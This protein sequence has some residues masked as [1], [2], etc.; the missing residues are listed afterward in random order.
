[1][2][3]RVR[4]RTGIAPNSGRRYRSFVSVYELTVRILMIAS[5]RS[6]TRSKTAHPASAFRTPATSTCSRTPSSNR[7]SRARARPP[8]SAVSTTSS[9]SSRASPT[10]ARERQ[11]SRARRRRPQRTCPNPSDRGHRGRIRHRAPSRCSGVRFRPHHGQR[12]ESPAGVNGRPRS[13]ALDAVRSSAGR[14]SPEGGFVHDALPRHPR[15]S[16]PG[17]RDRHAA[18]CQRRP[19]QAGWPIVPEQLKLL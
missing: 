11:A 5:T 3:A 7:G 4:S 13:I 9:E 12:A 8:P 1:M 19:V 14:S 15:R 16:A 2:V 17:R 6:P 18:L 10:R